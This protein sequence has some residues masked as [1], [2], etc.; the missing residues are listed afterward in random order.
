MKKNKKRDEFLDQLKKIP[1][2][3][4]ACEKVGLSRNSIYRWRKEDEAFS[5]VMDEALTEGE[6][7]VNDMSESQLLTMIKEKNWSAISFWLRHR[8]P[9]FR[10]KVEVTTKITS[11]ILTPEQETLVREALTLAGINQH[12]SNEQS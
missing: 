2:V 4:V 7:L 3:L 5:T 11:D 10:D 6:A 9:K 8:N 12:Q 1:I